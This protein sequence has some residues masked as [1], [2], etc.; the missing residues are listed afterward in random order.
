[1]NEIE[2]EVKQE[3]GKI[4]S[5]IKL[6]KE[7]IEKQMHVYKE[8]EVNENNLVERKGD[9]AT[10]NK[11]TKAI[12]D[13]RKVVK[14]EFMKP[15]D[16]FEKECKEV[17][18][19]IN[20]PI[21]MIDTQLK[22]FEEAK[23]LEKKKRITE[24][25]VDVIGEYEDIIPLNRIY[26]TKWENVSYSEKS[27]KDDI[28]LIVEQTAI[29]VATIKTMNSEFIDKGMNKYIETLNIALAVQEIQFYEK[30]KAEIL[31][32]EEAKKKAEEEAARLKAEEEEREKEAEEA[33][34]QMYKEELEKGKIFPNIPLIDNDIEEA[35]DIELEEAFD[36]PDHNLTC[37]I[38]VKTTDIGIIELNKFLELNG[39]DFEFVFKGG[40][41]DGE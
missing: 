36:I 14:K 11:I 6:I 9:R 13:Q 7:N 12:D 2:V 27:I 8:L 40:E 5:N 34:K 24:I 10:L 32:R 38:K 28:S 25:Y 35:F 30:Q 3:I 26:N 4:G 41:D 17:I 29:A 20:E 1:M 15:Y 18:A 31:A 33:M 19:L 21:I 37:T 16:E 23:K 22:Q 39:Y